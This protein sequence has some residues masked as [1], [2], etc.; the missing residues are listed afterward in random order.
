MAVEDELRGG[1]IPD[2]RPRFLTDQVCA[3]VYVF[4]H[5]YLPKQSCPKTDSIILTSHPEH[6]AKPGKKKALQDI[7]HFTC[8][9]LSKVRFYHLWNSI[10]W[11]SWHPSRHNKNS[12]DHCGQTGDERGVHLAAAWE[13]TQ[14]SPQ[15]RGCCY[16]PE[17]TALPNLL[18]D[19]NYI[20]TALLHKY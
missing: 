14:R 10:S 18:S 2:I 4:Y 9:H 1:A 13:G 20:T 7:M 3:C 6:W 12:S 5:P 16:F 17:C 15:K 19:Q 11:S 8:C